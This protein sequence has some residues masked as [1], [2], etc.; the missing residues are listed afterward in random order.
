MTDRV[1]VVVVREGGYSMEAIAS[2]VQC[3]HSA[4][5]NTLKR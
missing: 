4:V 5:S 1:K 2:T 3:S